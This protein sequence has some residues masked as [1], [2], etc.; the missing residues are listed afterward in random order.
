[1]DFC[2]IPLTDQL[3]KYLNKRRT[4]FALAQ[5]AMGLDSQFDYRNFYAN[6]P[7]GKVVILDNGAYETALDIN[8]FQC[9][10]DYIEPT[11]AVL[12]DIMLG[13]ADR[14][15]H[16]S[17]GFLEQCGLSSTPYHNEWM[18]VP[19]AAPGDIEGFARVTYQALQDK[20]ITWIGIPRCLV[21]DIADN[22]LARVHFATAIKK[23]FPHIKV[24][25][26]GMING[27]IPE[28]YYLQKAGVLSCDSSWP[29]NNGNTESNL[30]A[31]DKCLNTP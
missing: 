26:L 14:S 7:E 25:A 28:L 18:F 1:M 4:W 17:L 13:E 29:F 9:A 5:K 8:K 19:Q 12:P 10:I 31:I 15:L 6:A 2:P 30:E 23:D 27:C 3:S 24:H 20:R 21:T 11:V 22:P 16:L